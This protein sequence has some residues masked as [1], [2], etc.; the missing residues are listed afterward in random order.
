[1]QKAL[2]R[3]TKVLLSV[4]ILCA[5]LLIS[6]DSHALALNTT[7][8]AEAALLQA[9]QFDYDQQ[10]NLF[11]ASGNVQLHQDN[12]LITADKMTY[13]R[14]DDTVYAEGH[15]VFVDK[16]GQSYFANRA[17]LE[18]KMKKAAVE[19]IGLVMS[20]GSRFAARSGDQVDEN[21]IVMHDGIYSPC[22]LCADDPHKAP[23]WQMRASKIV[24]DKASQDVYYHNVKF[25]AFGVPVAYLPYFSHPDPNVK[26]RSGVLMPQFS[27]DTKKGFML[28][29]YYYKNISPSED[30]TLELS[31][32]TKAGTLVGGEYRRNFNNGAVK[33]NGSLN[34]S[35]VRGGSDDDDIIKPEKWRGHLF[36]NGYFQLDPYWGTGFNFKR[37][38]DNY[39]LRDFDF[40]TDDVLINNAFLQRIKGRDYTNFNATY[41][42]DLRPNITQEQPD[43]LPWVQHNLVGTP[44][45]FLGGRWNVNNE[46]ITLFRD[47]QQSVSRLST[48]P[49]WERRDILPLGLQSTINTKLRTDGYWVRKNSPFDSTTTD[50]NLDKTVG[51]FIP[52]AQ[53]TLAYPLIRPA[54]PVTALVEP[55]LA[56]T[57]APNSANNDSIPNEDSR[58]AQIDISNLF[59][60]NR[61]PGN[62]RVEN[63][64]HL[65]YGIKVGGYHDNGNS[66]FMTV[67]QSYRLSSN[68]PFP[69]GSGLED[70]RSDYVG[71]IESTF[72]NRFYVD[73]RFQLNEE[74]L[75]DRRHELQAAYLGDSIEA[76][77]NYIFA[78]QVQGT[79]L[80]RDRQQIGFSAAKALTKKWST[81]IDT[82]NDLSG[83]GGLLK[84]GGSLQY[85]NE[86]LRLTWRAERDLTDQ[87][88]GGS[89]T[90]FLF[91]LG[92]RNL[93][94]YDTPLLDNDP[95]YQAFGSG[96]SSL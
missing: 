81:A 44:N 89:D 82:L 71:Q 68:N 62:D 9:D 46:F 65:S 7:S 20:D 64:S 11:T 47:G 35:T 78:Q 37:T 4:L 33:F 83:D 12:Q 92:L 41:F 58:D 76:R 67:G 14:M 87:L 48:V 45:Q 94:G 38:T 75:D 91:S 21:T 79:G 73:Y 30:A 6:F 2:A 90:R 43:I 63:G 24:H 42:Q 66:M 86:C 85:K 69:T 27:T 32:T 8:S 28:R 53:T 10:K 22:N 57:V 80:P 40:S 13:S 26:A 70:H 34:R 15:V 51:R 19:Q 3:K 17:R 77:T 5:G 49:G 23:L 18:Q 52:T 95:L 25:D 59:D 54:S 29:N 84:A 96:K 74:N 93:G 39:Y 60:D 31:P 88:T 1:M 16:T 56:L 36:A 72:D 50:P 55:K 61:F